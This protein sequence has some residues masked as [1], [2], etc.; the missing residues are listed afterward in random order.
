MELVKRIEYSIQVDGTIKMLPNTSDTAV[1]G[2]IRWT[3]TDFEGF[4][5]AQWLSLT[6]G[7]PTLAHNT[8]I[9]KQG[10]A[11]NEFYHLSL[12]QYNNVI[13]LT[14]GIY[15]Q[16]ANIGST[17]ISST[18]WG[19]LGNMNQNVSTSS[20]PTFNNIVLTSLGNGLLQNVSGTISATNQIG[21]TGSR[22]AKGWFTDIEITNMPTVGGVSIN[23]NNVL[24]LTSNEVT[25]LSNID[26]NVI[27]NAQ[28][29]YVSNLNQNLGT[30]NSPSFVGLT[31]SGINDGLL[32]ID[33]GVVSSGSSVDLTADVF[34][35]LPIANG[36]TNA[37][38]PL[39]NGRVMISALDS[40]V[41]SDTISTTNLNVLS[42]VTDI[43][44]GAA[45]NDHITTKGYVDDALAS[46]ADKTYVHNQIVASA[47]WTINHNLGKYAVVTI[48]DSAS[49]EV[50]GDKEYQD[51][52]TVVMTFTAA[53]SGKAY[54]N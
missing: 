33:S 41:E 52:N 11:V 24:S 3:G 39:N 53:F 50:Y 42:G 25:Q 34:N 48:V 6:N 46:V 45:D 44:T 43:A 49:T 2:M 9:S 8:L 26:T 23:N 19:Y 13:S 35:I 29:G 17:S 28:W 38:A 47:T 18:K 12:A 54:V 20:I 31:L 7:I 37:S 27:T 15:L 32:R 30:T 22:I 4:I 1:A 40:I 21:T 16:L 5:G 36:G 14:T 51:M 10:G